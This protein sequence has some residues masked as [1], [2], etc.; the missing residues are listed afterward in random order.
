MPLHL[1]LLFLFHSTQQLYNQQSTSSKRKLCNIPP[2]YGRWGSSV[3]YNIPKRHI[4]YIK[5]LSFSGH[6]LISMEI[7]AMPG[8]EPLIWI[9]V[10]GNCQEQAY[11]DCHMHLIYVMFYVLLCEALTV[12]SPRVKTTA[13]LCRRVQKA[14]DNDV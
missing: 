6:S 4:I 9:S 5:I 12:S 14:F 11:P 10:V 8:W 13:S 2:E 3:S 7:I 1:G